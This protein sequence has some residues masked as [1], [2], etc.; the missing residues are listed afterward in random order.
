MAA[1]MPGAR[2]IH[3]VR[4]VTAYQ[5]AYSNEK[6]VS[7]DPNNNGSKRIVRSN[8]KCHRNACHYIVRTAAGSKII[9]II[10]IANI[11]DKAHY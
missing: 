6:L 1:F 7:S 9:H 5:F 11:N 4:D 10:L 8:V 3:A 2:N